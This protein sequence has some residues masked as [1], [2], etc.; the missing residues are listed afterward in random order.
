MGWGVS[1]DS[2]AVSLMIR[3]AGVNYDYG[4][5]K[6][7]TLTAADR[8]INVSFMKISYSQGARN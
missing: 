4:T 3:A 5:M 1:A 2:I 8:R 7:L 6:K